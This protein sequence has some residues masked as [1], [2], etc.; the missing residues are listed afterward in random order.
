MAKSKC[1]IF[2]N[3]ED[4]GVLDVSVHETEE[5]KEF[6]D[7][8]G[9]IVKHVTIESLTTITRKDG[10]E[11]NESTGIK[12]KS[13]LVSGGVFTGALIGVLSN[14]PGAIG[15]VEKTLHLI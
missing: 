3:S 2:Q 13:I 10:R 15:F 6:T 1:S 5:T 11:P 12:A 9:N 4:F 8:N 7:E 14:L